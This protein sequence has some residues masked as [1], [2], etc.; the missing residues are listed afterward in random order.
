MLQHL[1]FKLEV[2]MEKTSHLRLLEA[3]GLWSQENLAAF[4]DSH[5]LAETSHT[6]YIL[7]VLSLSSVFLCCFLPAVCQYNVNIVLHWFRA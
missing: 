2:E 4:T 1:V 6:N 5:L 7:V 3:S